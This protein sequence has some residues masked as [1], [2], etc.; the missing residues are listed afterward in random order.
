[1]VVLRQIDK[2]LV[3]KMLL[4]VLLRRMLLLAVLVKMF[5]MGSVS[6]QGTLLMLLIDRQKSRG[7]HM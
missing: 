3:Q 5:E 6:I 2:S 1:L 7:R 4:L